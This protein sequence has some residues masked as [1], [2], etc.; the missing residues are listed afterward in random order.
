MH[1]IFSQLPTPLN[2]SAYKTIY[3]LKTGLYGVFNC[4]S[5]YQIKGEKAA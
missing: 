4:P 1:F 5:S 2:S 3:I